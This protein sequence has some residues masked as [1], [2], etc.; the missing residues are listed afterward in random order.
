MRRGYAFV[1]YT[2]DINARLPILPAGAGRGGNS[3]QAQYGGI[4]NLEFMRRFDYA[5]YAP[6]GSYYDPQRFLRGGAPDPFL[7]QAQVSGPNWPCSLRTPSAAGPMAGLAV[8]RVYVDSWAAGG[9]VRLFDQGRH[10]QWRRTR[11]RAADRCLHDRAVSHGE[12]AGAPR[13]IPR[14]LPDDVPFVTVY[15]QS[16]TVHDAIEH[17]ALPPDSDRP[18][19]RYVEVMGT[20]HL[21]AADLG[22][23]EVEPLPNQR[24]HGNDPRCQAI[25]DEPAELPF[26][27]LL[28]AM[29]RWVRTGAP[30]PRYPRVVRTSNGVRRDPRTQAIVGGMRPPWITVPAFEYWTDFETGCGTV[31]DSKRGLFSRADAQALRLL[32]AL[33]PPFCRRHPRRSGRGHHL[34]GRCRRSRS[35][36]GPEAFGPF[37]PAPR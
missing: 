6:L 36:A 28:D 18:M 37:W 11:W 22:T 13:R 24:G 35:P 5:R 1:A 31:Y 7:P 32:R 29:D 4:V 30:M 14:G 12:V 34:A 19:L 20:P 21:R 23:G 27:A 3:D 8:R 25:Y 10:Q 15:S 9:L 17:I 16:E 2:L 26:S 33:C